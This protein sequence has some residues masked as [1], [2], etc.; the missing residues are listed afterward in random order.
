MSIAVP[1]MRV[2]KAKERPAGF[3]L[4]EISLS[5]TRFA[6]YA[7][8]CGVLAATFPFVASR[9]ADPGFMTS[10][11][12]AYVLGAIVPVAII[13]GRRMDLVEPLYWFSAKYYLVFP[14]AIYFL[15]TGFA[16]SEHLLHPGL[17]RLHALTERALLLF[18]LGYV[19]FL[20]GYLILM[21]DRGN[22][23]VLL[24][25]DREVSG[26][27]ARALIALCLFAG[28]LNFVYLL[29]SYPEGPIRYLL[30]FGRR[31]HRFEMIEGE[32]TTIGY[33]WLYAGVFL[34]FMILM[35]E[36]AI[37]RWKLQTWLFFGVA[38]LSAVVSVSQGR[39]TQSISYV[40]LLVFLG[41][42]CA[43]GQVR[44]HRF[45][46]VTGAGLVAGIIL[47]FLRQV[48]SLSY[49]GSE[50]FELRDLGRYAQMF[51]PA[52]GYWVVD[53]GNIP[54]LAAV[55]NL[56]NQDGIDGHLWYGKSFVLWLVAFVPGAEVPSIAGTVAQAWFHSDGGLPPTIVGEMFVNFGYVGVPVGLFVVGLLMSRF[57]AFVRHSG[58]FL[59]YVVFLSILF[60]FIFLWPKGEMINAVAAIWQ[61]IPT[62][63][64][65]A[66]MRLLSGAR[67]A[68][69]EQS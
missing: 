30:D 46:L 68:S 20:A 69:T 59:W 21:R 35:R 12:L 29:F 1:F 37:Q 39:L 32:V 56:L 48:S 10:L 41:Y 49:V 62:V 64:V 24:P 51:L 16:Y 25:T 18:L 42:V 53:K 26:W 67:P 63:V 58:H 33:Q 9:L 17:P 40:L 66:A 7:V 3:R 14:G 43:P 44:N 13:F 47:Y 38:A 28:L 36:G 61:F 60:K 15:V 34:W 52:L 2:P 11:V 8:Y 4:F 45:I 65:F 54:N 6:L 57:Y 23:R 55:V 22:R 27:V 50:A 31:G 19:A 5:Q